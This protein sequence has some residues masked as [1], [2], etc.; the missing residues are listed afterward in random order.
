MKTPE[1]WEGLLE[2]ICAPMDEFDFIRTIRDPAGTGKP[3]G[4]E[5]VTRGNP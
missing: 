3:R 5:E 1:G 4:A 2:D